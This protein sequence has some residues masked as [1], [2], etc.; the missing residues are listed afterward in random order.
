[1]PT[2]MQDS[3]RRVRSFELSMKVAIKKLEYREDRSGSSKN[4]LIP[5]LNE[6]RRLNRVRHENI[7]PIYGY[8]F[9][10]D[11]TCFVVFQLKAGRILDDRLSKR[12]GF[13]PLS[14]IHRWRIAKRTA[15]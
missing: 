13:E 14:L 5:L 2:Q 6:L 9:Q 11:G 10:E 4:H 3:I 15:R 1:M 12:I 8:A 7:L